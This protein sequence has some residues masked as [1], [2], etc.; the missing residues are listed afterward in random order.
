MSFTGHV[1]LIATAIVMLFAT[2][3]SDDD[4][5]EEAETTREISQEDI[6]QLMKL[7]LHEASLDEKKTPLDKCDDYLKKLEDKVTPRVRGIPAD[8]LESYESYWRKPKLYVPERVLEFISEFSEFILELISAYSQGEY[9]VLGTGFITAAIGP[10]L[11]L[12]G[13]AAW[14][15]A[16]VAWE[17]ASFFYL[18]DVW[19]TPTREFDE[20]IDAVR[21]GSIRGLSIGLVSGCWHCFKRY[22]YELYLNEQQDF[23]EEQRARESTKDFDSGPKACPDGKEDD[24]IGRRVYTPLGKLCSYLGKLYSWVCLSKYLWGLYGLLGPVGFIVCAGI[25]IL[26]AI[27]V[28]YTFSKH[29]RASKLPGHHKAWF[30]R[31]RSYL[32]DFWR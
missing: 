8:E 20:V 32:R 23:W 21:E 1:V 13:Y 12:C 25:A 11:V 10:A 5:L 26:V 7:W 17:V 2:A 19:L 4:L 9:G 22:R 30:R 18:F 28:A 15:A 3:S 14:G 6:N 24:F 16:L 29:I 27:W 31:I